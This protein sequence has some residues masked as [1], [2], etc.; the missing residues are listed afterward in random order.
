MRSKF[1][2]LIVF[3]I[4]IL[5]G[6]FSFTNKTF[7]TAANYSV[8]AD[9]D[10]DGDMDI[11]SIANGELVWFEN[12]GFQT[13]MNVKVISSSLSSSSPV[14]AIDLDR[15]GDMDIV[16]PKKWYDNN[17]SQSFTEKTTVADLLSE[18]P[19]FSVADMDNDGDFDIVTYKKYNSTTMQVLILYNGG[20][21]DFT[22][23]AI[24]NLD[25]NYSYSYS[26]DN[27]ISTV[28]VDR[29]GDM[30]VVTLGD[31][32]DNGMEA[33]WLEN[34]NS[35]KSKLFNNKAKFYY[36]L[37][38][39]IPAD[40]DSD[41]DIDFLL[42]KSAHQHDDLM[43]YENNGNQ[44]FSEREITAANF[45][46]K[47]IKVVDF[48]NDGDQDIVATSERIYEGAGEV[49][50]LENDGSQNFTKH[51]IANVS[52]ST[53]LHIT[54]IDSDGDL[55]VLL[56]HYL[57]EN[58]IDKGQV[59]SWTMFDFS[60]TGS[61][62]SRVFL[63]NI[64]SD[65]DLD[66]L[67]AGRNGKETFGWFENDGSSNPSWSNNE[68]REGNHTGFSVYSPV[69][70]DN[71]GDK[72]IITMYTVANGE[73]ENIIDWFE[74]DGATDPS[75]SFS[76]IDKNNNADIIGFAD[77]DND[78]DIDIIC[79]SAGK[80]AWFENDGE[81]DPSW[82]FRIIGDVDPGN[83]FKISIGD[84]DNDG[85]K[86]IVYTIVENS[87][88]AWYENDGA[89][90]PSWSSTDIKTGEEYAGSAGKPF[91]ADMDND[92]DMDFLLYLN[93]VRKFVWYENDGATD[94]S[95]NPE[96][97]MNSE[98]IGNF[99]VNDM[100]KDG[101]LD[102]VI[103]VHISNSTK[104]LGFHTEGVHWYENDGAA[105][106]SWT[107][108]DVY[109]GDFNY[110]SSGDIDRDGDIDIIATVNSQS[111]NK[112]VWFQN[113][114]DDVI[115][116]ISTISST[117]DDG[118]Y[119]IGDVIAVTVAWS[120]ATTVT[121]TP[122][123]KLE[124]GSTDRYANYASGST[125][126]TLTF[127]YTIAAGDT[128]ADLDYASTGALELNNGTIKDISS[129]EANLTLVSPGFS[130][131]LG[132][133]KT[134]IIDGNA[135]TVVSVNSS[136]DDGTYKTVG[137]T[138]PIMVAFSQL[139]NVTGI[140]QLTLETG[141]T[142]AVID[143]SSGTGTST[144]TF[145]Y[146][147]EDGHTNYDLG[148]VS[149]SALALNSGTIND[150]S[151]NV[152]I[153]TLANPGEANSLSAN[154]AIVVDP[155]PPTF[156]IDPIDGSAGIAV[157]SNITITFNEAVRNIDDSAL[158][159]TNVDGLITLKN[160]D[161]NGD[162][163]A[164]D[165][166]VNEGKTVITIDPASDFSS[167]QY[168]YVAIGAS[169]ED[170]V[171][172]PII[173]S[174]STFRAADIIIPTVTFDPPNGSQDIAANRN[175]TLTFSESI[176][177]IDNSEITDSNVDGL[178]SLK[179]NNASGGNF[180]FTA[181]INDDK[182]VI[183]VDPLFDFS[184]NTVVYVAID[185][186][187]EDDADNAI[188]ASSSI[189]RTGIPDL[190]G[191]KVINVS[192]NTPN[193]TYTERSTIVISVEFDEVAVVEGIP[194]ILLETGSF[195]EIISYSTG[196]GTKT[197]DFIYMITDQHN[198]SDL[199]YRDANSLTLNG[200]SIKDFVGNNANLAL[201][202]PGAEGSLGFN[203]DI[204]IDNIG[205]SV[206]AVSSSTENGA[207]KAGEVIVITVSL[208]E[209]TIVTGTPKITLETG[210]TDG[211][212]VYLSGSGSTA[213]SFNYTVEASHNSPDLDYVSIAALSLNGGTMKDMV[214]LNAD[215]TLPTPGEEGSLSSNK[216]IVID[217]I[218]PTISDA[219]A[220]DGSRFS[221]FFNFPI[222]FTTSEAVTGAKLNLQSKLGDSLTPSLNIDDPTH[223]SV[224]LTPPFTS[225]DELTLTI[226]EL[227][228]YAGNTTNDLVYNYSI[229]MISDWNMDGSIDAWDMTFLI[230]AWSDKDYVNELGPTIGDVPNLKPVPDGKFDIMDAAVL[231]RMWH[232]NQNK[233]GKILAR[234]INTG[235]DLEYNNEDNTL[236]I[237]I[238]DN[239]NAVDFY[240]QYPQD[241]I[242]ISQAANNTSDKEIV[243]TH[244]DSLR[245]E[246]II[247]AGYLEEMDR[248]LQIPYLIKG[249][250]DVTITAIY[251]MFDKNSAVSKQGTQ[252]ITLKAIPQ[253]FSLH[254]NYPNPFNPTTTINYDLPKNS[255]VSLVIY[256]IM[257]REVVSLLNKEL[258]GG[259]HSTVWN[260]RD[261][262][263]IP[264]SA[265]V[266]LYQL[267]TDGFIKTKKMILL[268]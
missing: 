157:S 79:S 52:P 58:T 184:S 61:T 228:D 60:I 264:V 195:D 84:M 160:K 182:T 59:A 76:N 189:F 18:P 5:F 30:D 102:F 254:Q 99:I 126:T 106:P 203:K 221:V 63:K 235:K 251:R 7:S 112:I 170:N 8:G 127:N 192:S 178:I 96:L 217:N 62:P 68:I 129:N 78:G 247:T 14:I 172:H 35:W 1:H 205:P 132:A 121:G 193:G 26:S 71:D 33:V 196:S 210:A 97:I 4:N 259:Y 166:S 49:A 40:L 239:V 57:L 115:P 218:A 45:K 229:S 150:P 258:T 199:D 105:D 20:S 260:T 230:N 43:W 185:A 142:D 188:S 89:A 136:K 114:F 74:N 261:N 163:I 3:S 9:L 51:T 123:I 187:V 141:A 11:I 117:N 209:T 54:D 36:S 143:Y 168:I 27:F 194:L 237:S 64:D 133:N 222:I 223:V 234:Y 225:L 173:A 169:L 31:M 153:L 42:G 176:R 32:S 120:E 255:R 119:K 41:G 204:A 131:S 201:P 177:N 94:P 135:P 72:D 24:F 219:S 125:T 83:L 171:G 44:S 262:N 29:D 138:I 19:G 73:H 180:N 82:T 191:P 267:Q 116:I 161:S 38:V 156:V 17:G 215:L 80:I 15:D 66:V 70:I 107:R 92:G 162:D 220:V 139:V 244:S 22:A 246:Y 240:L 186:V 77:M 198:T 91:I 104:D 95:W 232:W 111:G 23:T 231:I 122:R 124:T 159:D 197:L 85:D 69:D 21:Q 214:G 242:S 140:P 164:F 224:Y 108:N 12:D 181:T 268:K 109:G 50:V 28:D 213:L 53:Y 86:D 266:Y 179:A 212:G 55:D 252:E 216:N 243:L 39:I 206:T 211:V 13:F 134:I 175:I 167:D 145:N 98:Y 241:K 47:N 88:I 48:D 65:G 253:E 154:K 101:D 56:D 265:G 146:V 128:T 81:T 233:S 34:G 110:I 100:D 46:I 2:I 10:S 151:G 87:R 103:N 207:Y 37:N 238:A 90:D 249:R 113:S 25:Y 208:N 16:T 137:E 6:Q 250:E 190:T 256:D 263:G 226:Y 202:N 245:G 174:N 236:S 118:V 200:G 165:A 93:G 152:S 257:G 147:I 248:S 158:L 155:N 183:T 130:G 227:T 75:W 144:L 67:Y 148:Y 149:S